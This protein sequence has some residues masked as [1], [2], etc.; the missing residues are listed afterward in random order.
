C[1]K[2]AKTKH[3]NKLCTLVLYGEITFEE[4][5]VLQNIACDTKIQLIFIQDIR[6]YINQDELDLLQQ[7][8]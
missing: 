3:A 8:V 6:D 7:S 4:R 5:N 1:T 2:L